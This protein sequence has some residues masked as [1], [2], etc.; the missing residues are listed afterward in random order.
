MRI[1]DAMRF[2]WSSLLVVL[3]L[4]ICAQQQLDVLW[5]QEYDFDRDTEFNTVA[6]RKDGKIYVIGSSALIPANSLDVSLYVYDADNLNL[7]QSVVIVDNKSDENFED[8]IVGEEQILVFTSFIDGQLGMKIL[9]VREYNESE[10]TLGE[11]HRIDEVLTNEKSEVKSFSITS[12]PSGDDILIYHDNPSNSG[13]KVFNLKVVDHYFNLKWEK[14]L[15]LN[16][17]EKMVDYKDIL[18]DDHGNVYLLSTINP[19]GF[20]KSSG[21]GSLVNV[22]STLFTYRPYEDKL[23][24]FEFALSR[25]WIDEVSIVFDPFNNVIATAFYTY[26]NDYKIRGFVIFQIEGHSG[27]AVVKKMITLDKNQFRQV[28]KT[29]G[30]LK[31]YSRMLVG[32]TGIYPGTSSHMNSTSTEFF[33]HDIEVMENSMVMAIEAFRRDERCT[34]SFSDQQMIVF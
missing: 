24:E 8:I 9:S 10:N 22:K 19:F 29:I 26:P 4:S 33:V 25:N 27:E 13:F 21:L 32:S 34:E 5:S 6:G 15:S 20:S 30:R 17:K 23:K 11:L 14:E 28:D 1:F 12:S 3:S 16:Y 31:D 7:L 2:L 18:I